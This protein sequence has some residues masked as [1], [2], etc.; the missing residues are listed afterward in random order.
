[1]MYFI[2]SNL[3]N[4]MFSIISDKLRCYKFIYQIPTIPISKNGEEDI[5]DLFMAS[6]F[7]KDIWIKSDISV[8][9]E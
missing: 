8:R 1:M 5:S 9:K 2:S 4:F 7:L 6:Q 3:L